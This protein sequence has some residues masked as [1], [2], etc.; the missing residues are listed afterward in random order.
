MEMRLDS[1]RSEDRLTEMTTGDSHN[2]ASECISAHGNG[3]Y[4]TQVDTEARITRC[5]TPVKLRSSPSMRLET[6][7]LRLLSDQHKSTPMYYNVVV[8][9]LSIDSVGS[10]LPWHVGCMSS[11]LWFL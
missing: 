11:G 9:P 4:Q 2:W 5:R 6:Q 8:Q 3:C 1:M 10:R 7:K